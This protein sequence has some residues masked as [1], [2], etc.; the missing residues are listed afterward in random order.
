MFGRQ[1]VV[2]QTEW[3]VEAAMEEEF[4]A[5][6]KS[7]IWPWLKAEGARLLVAGHDPLAPP[8]TLVT[9][10]AFRDISEWHRLHRPGE[11]VDHDVATAWRH[12]EGMLRTSTTKILMVGT[13]YGEKA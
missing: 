3:L 2:A 10:T 7:V 13:D 4:V 9:L 11:K 5:V 12:R 1:S 6:S 8:G